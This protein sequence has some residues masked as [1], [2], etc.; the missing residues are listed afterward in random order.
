[1]PG[2]AHE[3]GPIRNGCVVVSPKPTSKNLAE[4]LEDAFDKE[5]S[6]EGRVAE[7]CNGGFRVQLKGKLAFCPISQM[8]NKRIDQPDLD[9]TPDDFLVLQNAGPKSGYAMPEAGYLPIPG[10]L[11]RAV[12]RR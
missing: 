11:A 12:T 9:V 6:V 3:A 10:K 5:L 7:V 8:D 2:T 4:D 1:M